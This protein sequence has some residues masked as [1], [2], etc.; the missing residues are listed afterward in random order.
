MLSMVVF[1]NG[2]IRFG[3]LLSVR[4]HTWLVDH[5]RDVWCLDEILVVVTF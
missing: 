1:S 5:E 3:R 4:G 2:V